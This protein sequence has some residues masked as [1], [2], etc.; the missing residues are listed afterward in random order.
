MTPELLEIEITRTRHAG[1]SGLRVRLAG[2]TLENRSIEAE[3]RNAMRQRQELEAQ[4]V[5]AG[6]EGR[7]RTVS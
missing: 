2:R 3:L 1:N 5:G 7:D 6:R 4:P